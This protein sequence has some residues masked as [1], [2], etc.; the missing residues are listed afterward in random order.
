M[1]TN[2]KLI[3]TVSN[4]IDLI[5]FHL[6]CQKLAKFSGL[7]PKGPYLS[8]N[9]LSCLV[10]RRLS[11]DENFR[12]KEGEKEKRARRRSASH[13]LFPIVL[14]ASSS[15]TRVSLAFSLAFVQKTRRLRRRQVCPLK[16]TGMSTRKLL[17]GTD[18]SPEV[19]FWIRHCGQELLLDVL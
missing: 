9:R 5:Q 3:R 16:N 15:V 14:C 8:K 17:T 13:F 18:C 1:T 19:K 11:L 4:F 7:N 12:I 6:I 2:R 10:L